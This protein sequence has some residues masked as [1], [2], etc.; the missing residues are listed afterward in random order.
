MS[1][2][3]AP[4]VVGE[5]VRTAEGGRLGVPRCWTDL[6]AA[7]QRELQEL[8]FWY[9]GGWNLDTPSRA[10]LEMLRTREVLEGRCRAAY[11]TWP[12]V[13]GRRPRVRRRRLG[14]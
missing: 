14:T 2:E 10:A 5:W 12:P 13:D 9:D 3:T 11:P 8:T 6:T 4:T 1:D 7:E